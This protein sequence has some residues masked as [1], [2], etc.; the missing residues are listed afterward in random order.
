MTVRNDATRQ[1]VRPK[2]AREPRS[3]VARQGQVLLDA[4]LDEQARH[5]LDRVETETSDV[6][7]LPD[8][9]VVPAGSPGFAI[10]PTN[11]GI[12][13]GHGYLDGWLLDNPADTTLPT[14]PHPRTDTVAYPAA[15]VV[16]AL[17]RHVDPVEE[18]AWADPALGDAQASG[19]ALLDWQVFPFALA[20]D[21]ATPPGCGDVPDDPDWAGLVA[22][23]N[24]TLTVVPDTAPPASDPCSLAPAGGYSRAENLLYRIEVHG[25]MPRPDLPEADGPRFGLDGLRVKMSRRNASVMAA[26]TKVE[27]TTVTVTP[28]VLDP[29]NWF[30]P[31]SYAEVVSVHDDVDPRAAAAGERLFRVLSASD[32]EV[33]LPA[34]AAALLGTLTLPG[35]YLRLWDA[36]PDGAGVATASTSGDATMSG[37]IDLG[38]GLAVRLG[39]G[40]GTTGTI[41]RRGDHWTFTARADGSIDWPVGAVETP[42]GPEV[43]YASLAVVTD[44]DGTLTAEDCRVPSATLTDRV[45]LYRGG[46]GQEIAATP[47]DELLP[48][49]TPPTVAV[50]RG[51]APVVGATVRWSVPEGDPDGLLDGQTVDSAGLELTTGAGGLCAVAW[52]ID[53][54]RADRVHRVRAQLLDDLGVDDGPP[55]LFTASFRTAARTSYQPGACEV[56]A[57]AGTVQEALDEL[58]RNL[59]PEPPTLQIT[60]I[61]LIR[62]QTI[63]DLLEEDLIRTGRE[64]RADAF[65]DG[66]EIGVSGPVITPPYREFDQV[67]DVEMDL[68]YPTT[69]PE[70][71]YWAEASRSE[72]RPGITATFGFTRVRLDGS[73]EVVTKDTGATIEHGLRWVP[74]KQARQFLATLRFHLGGYKVLDPVLTEKLDWQIEG[75]ARLLCR[76][77]V[78]AVHVWSTGPGGRPVYLNAEYLGTA[79]EGLAARPL[80]VEERDPQRAGDLDVY[81]YLAIG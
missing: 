50:M 74:G 33:V 53:A 8:R 34:A 72:E 32:T 16:K 76:L 15:L 80:S 28:P 41:L 13:P 64:V 12:G 43:R 81:F 3:V 45:L 48:L 24:G 7:G 77:R 54:T 35:W 56:L 1:K 52:S 29:L 31:G 9:F 27:G 65:V 75:P 25:G 57:N 22:P 37:R 5:V 55:I 78:R 4:D 26:V 66:I 62:R 30:A 11:G 10:D 51:R 73:V 60:A 69:D 49:P 71:R 38:D 40:A 6:L 44:T 79:R 21:G 17:V 61:R 58:C 2:D 23:S 20:G 39:A 47:P 63:T 36:F 14:Q 67:V 59:E 19:R 18:P 42:H 46:D 68:P 70:R